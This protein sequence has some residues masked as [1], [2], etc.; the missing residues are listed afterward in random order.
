[1]NLHKNSSTKTQILTKNPQKNTKNNTTPPPL[2][3]PPPFHTPSPTS[4]APSIDLSPPFPLFFPLKISTFVSSKHQN[5]RE[6][7]ETPSL[8]RHLYSQPHNNTPWISPYLLKRHWV[9]HKNH[10]RDPPTWLHFINSTMPAWI[11]AHVSKRWLRDHV[12]AVLLFFLTCFR[13][14]LL[15]WMIYFIWF[16]LR[17]FFYFHYLE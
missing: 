7:S 9:I 12:T 4:T 17:F 10:Y 13:R 8:A 14:G 5:Q 1:M 16:I 3:R 11:V 15:L 6:H 2:L